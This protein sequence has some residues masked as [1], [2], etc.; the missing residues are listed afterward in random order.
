M[1]P[2]STVNADDTLPASLDLLAR[3]R[4]PY[5]GALAAIAADVLARFPPLTGG[6]SGDR[7]RRGAAARL[8]A[9]SRSRADG[10]HEPS[11]RRRIAAGV[12]PMPRRASAAGAAV[13]GRRVRPCLGLCVFDAI[14]DRRRPSPRSRACSRPAGAS[15]TCWTWRRCS[16]SRS[17]S[18][19]GPSWCPSRT[20]SA[21]RAITSGRWT[22]CCC[23]ATGWRPAALG[24]GR[25]PPVRR[26]VRDASRRFSPTG[27][28]SPPRPTRSRRWPAAATAAACWPRC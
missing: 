26:D 19:P 7:R 21:I 13:R 8:A 18:S 9:G 6:P 17:P 22:S 11:R 16:S 15:F 4:A 25:R 12:A 1:V 3:R 28:T 24:G 23:G 27:T 2:G 20:C 5:G 10:P 14:A